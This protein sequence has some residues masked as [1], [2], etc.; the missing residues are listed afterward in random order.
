MVSTTRTFGIILILLGLIGYFGTGRT[1]ATAL[2]PACFGALFVV[3]ALVGRWEGARKHAMHAA[4]VVALLG[5]LATLARLAPAL[6]QGQF[7]RP[8]VLAQLAM[9]ALLIVYIAL[10]IKSFKDARRLRQSQAAGTTGG[11]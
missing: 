2:I 7:G 3:L 11:R 8:S 10:G 6:V 5:L 4:V 9:S 1:S